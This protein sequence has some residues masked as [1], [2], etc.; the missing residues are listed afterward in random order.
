MHLY[1]IIKVS[2]VAIL[3]LPFL[4]DGATI[5]K[6]K[7]MM[8]SID[9]SYNEKPHPKPYSLMRKTITS[10]LPLP[11]LNLPPFLRLFLFK[12]LLPLTPPYS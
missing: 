10:L 11:L 4:H 7:I 8:L 5:T 6:P 2:L 12:T 3:P 9:D 1:P